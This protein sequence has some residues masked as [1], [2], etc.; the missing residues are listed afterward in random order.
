MLLKLIIFCEVVYSKNTT[1]F[2]LL[3]IVVVLFVPSCNYMIAFSIIVVTR[4]F[5]LLKYPKKIL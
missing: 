1:L 5:Y 4:F 3:L 2:N